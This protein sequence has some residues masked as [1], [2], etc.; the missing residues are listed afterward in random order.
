MPRPISL[1]VI[2]GFLG[3]AKTTWLKR[4]MRDPRQRSFATTSLR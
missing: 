1:T 4:L 2:G 3:F